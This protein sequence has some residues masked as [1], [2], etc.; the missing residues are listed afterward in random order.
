[1]T[2]DKTGC[3]EAFGSVLYKVFQGAMFGRFHAGILGNK[4]GRLKSLPFP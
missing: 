2:I 3:F 1:M 4:K